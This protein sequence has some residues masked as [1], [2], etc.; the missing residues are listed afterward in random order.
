MFVP[1]MVLGVIGGLLGALFSVLNVQFG[2][3][4]KAIVGGLRYKALQKAFL[5]IEPNIIMVCISLPLKLIILSVVN[6]ASAACSKNY[7]VC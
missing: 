3:L 1:A 5:F 7:F 2:R 6:L 4:R